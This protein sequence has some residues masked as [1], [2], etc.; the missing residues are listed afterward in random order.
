MAT[1]THTNTLQ[2]YITYAARTRRDATQ[3]NALE[4][5]VG[6][7]RFEACLVLQI[8]LHLLHHGVQ[9]VVHLL[10]RL[11]GRRLGRRVV[12]AHAKHLQTHVAIS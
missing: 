3:R 6:L 4:L 8:G 5:G 9:G 7:V 10:L 1:H 11:F 2:Q 12:A